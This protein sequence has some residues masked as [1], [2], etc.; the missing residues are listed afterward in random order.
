VTPPG[1]VGFLIGAAAGKPG[2]RQE[3]THSVCFI[4][5]HCPGALILS[6][7]SAKQEKTTV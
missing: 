7:L 1:R 6:M 5:E 3:K 4:S 2:D